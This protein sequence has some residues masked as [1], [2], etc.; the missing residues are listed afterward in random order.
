MKKYSMNKRLT[1]SLGKFSGQI[2]LL[3]SDGQVGFFMSRRCLPQFFAPRITIL[4][5]EVFIAR[6]LEYT[7]NEAGDLAS[8]KQTCCDIGCARRFGLYRLRILL[9]HRMERGVSS[10]PDCSRHCFLG[11]TSNVSIPTVFLLGN[12]LHPW[13]G[14]DT[15]LQAF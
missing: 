14:Q 8:K 11:P 13:T 9:C 5:V 15:S 2:Q 10:T 6:C 7:L 12:D 3:A 1:R 4:S